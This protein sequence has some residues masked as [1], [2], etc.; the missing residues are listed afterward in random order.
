MLKQ[1]IQK[2][3]PE[4]RKLNDIRTV[5]MYLFVLIVLAIAWSSVKTIQ[6]NYELQKQ[7]SLLQKQNDILGIAN[8]NINLQ[9]KY[10]Q[11]DQY[12]ELAARQSL[13][14]AAPGEKVVIVPKNVAMKYV[15]PSLSTQTT[16]ANSTTTDTR[17]RYVKN[18]EAWRDFLLGRK[19]IGD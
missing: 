1:I 12:L 15:D 5:A 13:G 7:I 14:L 16:E 11:T 6:K 19:V 17:S 10:L 3:K 9:N 4:V 8:E 18:L 2:L